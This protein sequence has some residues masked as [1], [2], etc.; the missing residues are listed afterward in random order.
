MHTQDDTD[1][2]EEVADLLKPFYK[3]TI[4]ISSKDAALALGPMLIKII[5]A[6]V[7][8]RETDGTQRRALRA[9][10]EEKADYY[11]Y[12]DNRCVKKAYWLV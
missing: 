11:F 6:A 1:I 4:A 12:D 9:L 10:L 8:P 5:C 2:L 3:A 7:S